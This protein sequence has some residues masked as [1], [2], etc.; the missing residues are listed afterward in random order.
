[1]K[2]PN[3]I[4]N[5]FCRP[6]SDPLSDGARPW[7]QSP[8]AQ[9]L[10]A[11]L[12][13]V[14]LV[15]LA[16]WMHVVRE[17]PPTLG[18]MLG[19]PLVG[20]G[21]LIIWTLLVHRAIGGDRPAA[22]GLRTDR[23]WLEGVLGVVLAGVLLALHMTL[24]P[25][26]TRLFPPQPAPEEILELLGGLSRSPGLL[27]LWLGPVVWIGVAGFE[28]L[29]R[30]HMLRRLWRVL[31]GRAGNW[32]VIVGCAALVAG[33]HLYQ[34]PAI[35]LSIFLLSLLKGWYFLRT[36]RFWSL[37]VAH[38]LYDS[39]QVVTMVIAIRAAGL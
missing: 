31:P 37:V 9:L 39:A 22:L 26:L 38:A 19:G 1:M 20:G 27:A 35:M 3:W 16:L 17:A 8:G 36:G 7:Q 6:E 4:P 30:V 12:A 24:T 34:P 33:V 21:T 28:E 11:V 29:W 5:P 23:W 10:G 15:A 14:P 32:A 2:I 13:A 18:L 25:L